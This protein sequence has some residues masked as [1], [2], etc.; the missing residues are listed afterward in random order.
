MQRAVAPTG[1]VHAFDIDPFRQQCLL[2][3]LDEIGFTL[4]YRDAIRAFE[5][6]RA[7]AMPWLE[8]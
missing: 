3:G 1:K 7:N 2:A 8:R 5:E 6:A 4:Q